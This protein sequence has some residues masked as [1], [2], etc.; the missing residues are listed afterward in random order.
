[1]LLGI[2]MYTV[3]KNGKTMNETGYDNDLLLD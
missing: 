3:G 2:Q 1:M